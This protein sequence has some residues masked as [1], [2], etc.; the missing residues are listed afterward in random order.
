MEKFLL[1]A[2]L[3][4]SLIGAGAVGTMAMGDEMGMMNGNYPGTGRGGCPMMDDDENHSMYEECEE[5]MG[6]HCEDMSQEDCE[7]MHEECEEHMHEDCDHEH[8]KA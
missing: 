3:I 7:E 2:L 4:I 6:E 5:H 1:I 8:E